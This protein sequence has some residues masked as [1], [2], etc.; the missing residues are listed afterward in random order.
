MSDIVIPVSVKKHSSGGEDMGEYKLSEHQ[1][2]GRKKDSAA[3]LQSKGSCK[4]IYLS[5]SL[6]I[7]IYIYIYRYMYIYIYIY[8]YMYVCIYIYIY[9][10][11]YIYTC[12]CMCVYIYIYIYIYILSFADTGMSASRDRDSGIRS[13]R[14][15]AR[16][17]GTKPEENHENA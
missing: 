4:R 9:V 7:N 13:A 12:I 16:G 11:I 17:Q 14:M 10:Y 15:A 2:R 8:V 1:L 6:Y 5:L 3:G